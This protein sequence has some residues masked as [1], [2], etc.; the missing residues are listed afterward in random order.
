MVQFVIVILYNCLPF[1]VCFIID[2]GGVLI[3]ILTRKVPKL[4]DPRPDFFLYPNM[5]HRLN[6]PIVLILGLNGEGVISFL[7]TNPHVYYP[8][9]LSEC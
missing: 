8:V 7:W 9:C 1:H 5:Q 3:F 2:E 6:N 4:E